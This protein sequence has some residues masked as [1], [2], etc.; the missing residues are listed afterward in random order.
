[1]LLFLFI[2]ECM[3]GNL[4]IAIKNMITI[5]EIILKNARMEKVHTFFTLMNM[6][7]WSCNKM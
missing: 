6:T 4:Q 3:T 7:M 2:L 5:E 1:M